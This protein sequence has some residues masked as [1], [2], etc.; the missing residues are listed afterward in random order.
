MADKGNVC[1]FC[2]KPGK[3]ND[4]NK[5]QMCS[6]CATRYGDLC[7]AYENRVA[8]RITAAGWKVD[9][10]SH[11]PQESEFPVSNEPL[12]YIRCKK[13]CV[14]VT[15]AIDKMAFFAA[16]SRLQ[17]DMQT[18]KRHTTRTKKSIKRG[19]HNN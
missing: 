19:K 9:L 12:F 2:C 1:L 3:G 4:V 17:S 7:R 6:R 8:S 10:T 13:G 15:T 18:P 14:T 16:A 11:A 5:L